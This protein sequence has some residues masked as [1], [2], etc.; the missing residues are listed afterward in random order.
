[1]AKKLAKAARRAQLIETAMAIVREEGA[2]ALTL[3][4]LAERAGVSK[5]V[6]YEH[7]ET[8]AGLMIALCREI[9]EAQV[10]ALKAAIAAAPRRLDAI[11]AIVAAAYMDCHLAIGPEWHAVTAALK[12]DEE[13]DRAGQAMLDGYARL[14]VDALGP[15]SPLAADALHLRCVGL[16]GAGE[17]ISRDMIR[18]RA[19]RAAAV[20]AFT[21]LIV[22]GLAQ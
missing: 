6:A 12:G 13:M 3:G 20:A 5:P 2:D 7:F 22:A 1:M 18:G 17:A 4:H 16:I 8:R 15:F 21:A 10:V 14:Y 11:A 19:D 9:D